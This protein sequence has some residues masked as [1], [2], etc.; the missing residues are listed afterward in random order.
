[1]AVALASGLVTVVLILNGLR[2]AFL[3]HQKVGVRALMLTTLFSLVTGAL[4]LWQ[5]LQL[6]RQ[7]RG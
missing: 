1:M 2:V 5:L 3:R 6:L 7:L 4:T